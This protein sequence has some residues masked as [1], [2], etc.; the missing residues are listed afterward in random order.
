MKYLIKRIHRK[1]TG[2]M[3][4][5]FEDVALKGAMGTYTNYYDR[6]TLRKIVAPLDI[7]SACEIGC[8]YGRLTMVLKEFANS[9]VGFER[10]I[11]LCGMPGSYF[12]D[13]KF[14]KV[15]SI[16]NLTGNFDLTMT[17]TLLQ[18]LTDDFC[19]KV[20][21]EAKRISN[22]YILLNEK[23]EPINVTKNVSNGKQFISRA[24]PVDIY[25][26]Y[27][28]PYRFISVH[29]RLGVTNP[30][31]NIRFMLFEKR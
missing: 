29:K 26:E 10:D 12:P 6:Q 15:T 11:G 28:K 19:R 27:M 2:D 13:I 21:E 24:R 22:R 14:T 3:V 8:G 20:L 18:H 4:W 30:H 9:V 16:D 7:R 25:T 1:I 23:T 31:T 17:H 5:L